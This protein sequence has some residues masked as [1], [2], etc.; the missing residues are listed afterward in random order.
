MAF[1]AVVLVGAVLSAE[2]RNPR[3]FRPVNEPD[4]VDLLSLVEHPNTFDNR[5]VRVR[6][7]FAC[8]QRVCR[9]YRYREL[10]GLGDTGETVPVTVDLPGGA[11]L[12]ARLDRHF[13]VVEGLFDVKAKGRDPRLPGG[14]HHL[15]RL[16]AWTPPKSDNS[17]GGSLIE[18]K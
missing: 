16:E 4:E 14:L 10:H 5:W 7:Y 6:A 13:V 9:L 3:P 15:K 18:V 11:E 12:T 17:G 8:E 1:L 2:P